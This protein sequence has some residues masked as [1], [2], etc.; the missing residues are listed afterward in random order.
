MVYHVPNS[1]PL[2]A[3]VLLIQWQPPHLYK[4]RNHSR[5]SEKRTKSIH[6]QKDRQRPWK[7]HLEWSK[8]TSW[9]RLYSLSV[10]CDTFSLSLALD[11]DKLYLIKWKRPSGISE[12]NQENDGFITSIHVI[13]ISKNAA[14]NIIKMMWTEM[15]E[16]ITRLKMLFRSKTAIKIR[17]ARH[18]SKIKV[19]QRI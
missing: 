6:F 17:F 5:S 8:Y 11:L 3:Y 18:N 16:L 15:M 12:F 19:F 13:H 9:C 4:I 1:T 2:C 10:L 14:S 7:Y